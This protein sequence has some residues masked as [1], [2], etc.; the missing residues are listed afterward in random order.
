MARTSKAMGGR[1]ATSSSDVGGYV[2]DHNSVY[3][4]WTIKRMSNEQGADS[5][6]ED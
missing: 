1:V 3:G 6:R 5:N 2:L 4:G